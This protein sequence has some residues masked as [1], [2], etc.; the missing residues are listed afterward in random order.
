MSCTRTGKL[1]M[2]EFPAF[3][4]VELRRTDILTV[5]LCKRFSVMRIVPALPYLVILLLTTTI[6][7]ELCADNDYGYD[8]FARRHDR[9]QDALVAREE[10][11]GRS[12]RFGQLDENN[13]NYITRNEYISASSKRQQ[14]NKLAPSVKREQSAAVGQ[15]FSDLEYA[16]VDGKSLKLDLSMPVE[17][18]VP[19]PLMVWI[20]GGGWTGGDK[21]TINPINTRLT[22]D[23]YAVASINYRLGGVSALHPKQIHDVKGA[24]RWLRAHA[25]KYG[26]DSTR[27]AVGG[28]SAGGHLALLLGLSGGVTELEGVVGGYVGESSSVQAVVDLYGVSSMQAYADSN[29]KFQLNTSVDFIHSASPIEYISSDDPPVLIIHGENDQTIPVNQSYILH[30]RYH[31]AGLDSSLN[32][33]EGGEHGGRVYHDET[34]YQLIKQFLDKKVRNSGVKALPSDSNEKRA[35]DVVSSISDQEISKV[36]SG[37]SALHGFHWMIG[38]K[39]GLEGTD[40][41]FSKLLE[42]IDRNLSTNEFISGVYVITH[43]DLIET[44]PGVFNFDRLDQI[45]EL[46]RRHNRYYKLSFN[47]GIYAP[48]W[49]YE[50]GAEHFS[51]LGSNPDRKEIYQKEIR[52]PVPW[53]TVFTNYYF[54]LLKEVANRYGDDEAFRGIT[55]TVA[56]FMSPEWY[57]P[58]SRKDIEQ[59][60]RLDGFPDKL[61]QAWKE[62]IDSFATLFPNQILVLEASS[63]P[64]GLKVVGDNI[65]DY[66]AKKYSDRFAVQMN[67]LTGRFDQVN[68]STFLK[69]LQYREKYGSQLNLGLQNLKG[70]NTPKL[71]KQQGSMDMTAFNFV[72]ADGDYWELWHSDGN[73]REICRTLYNLREEATQHGLEW[74]KRKLVENGSYKSQTE[75]TKNDPLVEFP[76]QR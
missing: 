73:D 51:T 34:R 9:N 3:A 65:V 46:I 62:G 17:S 72:Q 71:Q 12:K 33:V 20:H 60:E 40:R 54:R 58:H 38:P 8:Q 76:K 21:T 28:G 15:V 56:T 26:F 45:I 4:A 27:I 70:W 6:S 42:R 5:S 47:P 23:G 74:F 64:V 50:K 14:R 19:P 59:W 25:D 32:I 10:F 37:G 18:T 41:R 11:K 75:P 30:D 49:L 22:E 31:E 53:D 13:D 69:M 63:Y 48:D 66:A 1:I 2:N 61:E 39:N 44:A 43:W 7:P 52:I 55:L 24:I 57:L 68:R 16:I 67:Q 35:E 36:Q 29:A